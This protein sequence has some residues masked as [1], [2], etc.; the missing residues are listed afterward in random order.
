M[1]VLKPPVVLL[2][3]ALLP[4][5]V[6]VLP[7]LTRSAEEPNAVLLKPLGTFTSA[8]EPPAV[9]PSTSLGVGFGGPPQLA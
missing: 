5:A 6:L 1:A 4:T 8:F 2:K 3:S 9:L 7:M